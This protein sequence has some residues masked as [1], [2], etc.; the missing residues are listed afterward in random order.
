[1]V[2]CIDAYVYN[3]FFISDRRSIKDDT[4]IIGVIIGTCM[5]FLIP[6]ASCNFLVTDS[7]QSLLV[8]LRFIFSFSWRETFEL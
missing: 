5:L 3:Y 8:L 4:N 1:M 6:V 2:K 7:A